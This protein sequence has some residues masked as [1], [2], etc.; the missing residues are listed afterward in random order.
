MSCG[1]SRAAIFQ[2]IRT[3]AIFAS[4]VNSAVEASIAISTATG[5]SCILHH[6]HRIPGGVLGDEISLLKTGYDNI[7]YIAFGDFERTG[8]ERRTL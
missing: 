1:L 5:A 4:L 6:R 7:G 2:V 3:M 8:P